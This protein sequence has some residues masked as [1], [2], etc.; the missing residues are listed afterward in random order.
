MRFG[1]KKGP[2]RIA[3]KIKVDEFPKMLTILS[4]AVGERLQPGTRPS[5]ESL[6]SYRACRGKRDGARGRGG[7]LLGVC[8]TTDASTTTT[9]FFAACWSPA[10]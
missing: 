9:H 2:R 7:V 1:R 10:L 8:A 5:D 6:G 3:K 4:P